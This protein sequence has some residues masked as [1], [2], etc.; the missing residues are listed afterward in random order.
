MIPSCVSICGVN[1]EVSFVGDGYD[2]DSEYGSINYN[3]LEIRIQDY[4][5]PVLNMQTLVHEMLHAIS[6]HYGLKLD[7]TEEK[8]EQ[9]DV[10]ASILV[11]TMVRNDMLVIS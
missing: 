6:H 11:D 7:D 3:R 8:H 2:K 4:G 5:D 10:L 9:M 1:Y